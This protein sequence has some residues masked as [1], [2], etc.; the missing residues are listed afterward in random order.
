MKAE[1]KISK[2]SLLKNGFKLL[3]DCPFLEFDSVCTDSRLLNESEK[4]LFIPLKGENFDAH[5]FIGEL[6][7]SNKISGFLTELDV[8]PESVV[9]KNIFAAHSENNLY[10]LGKIAKDYR[11]NFSIPVVGITGTN[12]KTTTKELLYTVLSSKMNTHKNIKNYNNE[13]GV[14]FTLFG[15]KKDHETAVIEMGMNHAGEISRLSKMV[16]PNIAVIT[17]AGEGHLEYL[18]SVENVAL[19][20]SEI[21]NGMVSG[22]V[23]LNSDSPYVELMQKKAAEKGLEIYT[24]GIEKKADFMPESYMLHPRETELRFKGIDF[25]VPLYGLHNLYNISAALAAAHLMGFD[26]SCSKNALAAFENAGKRSEINH[27]KYTIINDT[28]NSNPLSLKSA[29]RSLNEIYPERRKVALLSDM[30]ELGSEEEN[31]HFEAGKFVHQYNFDLLAVY[32]TLSEKIAEGAIAS[33]MKRD[34]VKSF[35]TKDDFIQRVNGLLEEGDVILVKGSRS[36]K[37]EEVADAI[38]C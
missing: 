24:F 34:K 31:M 26:I 18:G 32:G 2:D 23:L 28:Y 15:L 35:T 16:Q 14:P 36:M 22:K 12:G 1:I 3:N 13:I 6:C 5:D 25:R 9:N 27:G 10:A 19:A 8:V 37:M 7:S 4:T 17:N 38:V 11:N 21:F 29:L 33:G 30:K 20:K